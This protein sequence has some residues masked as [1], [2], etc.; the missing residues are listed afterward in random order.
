M[1]DAEFACAVIEHC[2]GYT[3]LARK[4]RVSTDTVKKIRNGGPINIWG[5]IYLTTHAFNH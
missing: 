5:T 4:A 1:N 3:D 2:D